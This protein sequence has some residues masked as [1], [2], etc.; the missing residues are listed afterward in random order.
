M[1][2]LAPRGL[3]VSCQ[4]VPGSPFDTPDGVVAFARA[5]A[6]SGATGL[7][8]EGAANVAAVTQALNLPVIG[9][10]KRDLPGSDVR[11]TP[12]LEDVAALAAAGA[13][14]IA[15]DAT[16]RPRP[17]AVPD[18][19]AA[20]R[21]AG[22][23]AMADCAT[24]AE[25]EAAIAAGADIVGSTM[26]GYTGGPVPSAP[27]VAL[28]RALSRLGVPVLA[29]GRYNAPHL[30]AAAIRAGA[31]AVVVGSAITRPEHITTWFA[32]A[33]R[34]AVSQNPVMA[35][36]IGG[37]KTLAALVQNGT[38]LDRR[39]IP[40]DRDVG[41]PGWA[42]RIAALARDWRGQADR[43]AIAATGLIHNGAWSALNPDVLAI[44]PGFRLANRLS[45]A[46]GLPTLAVNDA[47]AAAWGEHRFGA[48]AGSD[49]LFITVSSGIGGG[50]V[51]GG[52][53]LTGARG[54]A[55]SLGQFPQ[56]GGT[57]ESIASG[58]GMVRRVR[59]LGHDIDMPGLFA[60][61]TPWAEHLLDAAAGALANALAGVQALLDPPRIVLGG[62]VGLAPGFLLR[63]EA[64][65]SHHHEIFIPRIVP[66]G[67]RADAGIIGVAALE[68]T[69]LAI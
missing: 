63:L 31:H 56:P 50:I 47:Q 35:F 61:G 55:G 30:A 32:E 40:T 28:V 21:A 49:L 25:A 57:L 34:A 29:E 27:D 68:P 39:Q 44:P 46:L 11:I 43:A 52:K 10:I 45:D 53:L 58:F 67:L 20:I 65:L 18:L 38:V 9:L 8:I 19:L 36:D 14:I 23:L 69:D 60:I 15:V 42:D 2:H 26:S 24:L 54:L 6:A 16:D 64:A 62:G 7:R 5:A 3:I 13:A 22:R 66:A 1:I 51:R 33:V 12:L 37:T 17:V 59:A 41:G 4:P 48:G